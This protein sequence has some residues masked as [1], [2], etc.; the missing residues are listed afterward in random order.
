MVKMSKKIM[1]AK[2]I[3]KEVFFDEPEKQFYSNQKI[4]RRFNASFETADKFRLCYSVSLNPS[5]IPPLIRMIPLSWTATSEK[6]ALLNMNVS[7]ITVD[8]DVFIGKK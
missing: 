3:N 5:W 4:V 8:L 1:C 6:E 7:E 2:R